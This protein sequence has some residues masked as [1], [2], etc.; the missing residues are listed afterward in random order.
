M[1]SARE[2]VILDTKRLTVKQARHVDDAQ[3]TMFWTGQLDLQNIIREPLVQVF[4]DLGVRIWQ[5]HTITV[6]I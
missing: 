6:T 3:M 2:T 1:F 4:Q 5:A